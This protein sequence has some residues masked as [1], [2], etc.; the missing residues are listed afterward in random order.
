MQKK[1]AKDFFD[2]LDK[3]DALRK[4]VNEGLVK[5]ANEAG[6]PDLSEEE[7]Q[8]ELWKRW[9]TTIMREGFMYS[10]PPGF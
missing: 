6:F 3:N 10:E 1:T 2:E 8:E 7:L 5:L 4:T 9:G